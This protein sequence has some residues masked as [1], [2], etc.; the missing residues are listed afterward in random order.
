MKKTV[1]ILS[2]T[3]ILLSALFYSCK[4][5]DSTGSGVNS[6]HHVSVFLT[7]HATPI[8]DSVFI[9]ILA[10]DVKTENSVTGEEAWVSVHITPGIYNILRLRNGLD[11]LF[12]TGSLP[13][14]GIRKLRL[15]LGTQNSVMKNNQSFPLQ[16]HDEDR[17]V[18]VDIDESEFEINNDQIL[19]WI[20]FDAARSIQ[21]DNSGQGNN[22]G[23]RLKAHLN[24]FTKHKSGSLEGRV[25]PQSAD[26]LVMAINGTDTTMAVP[27]DDDGEFKI[28]GLHAGTYRVFYDGQNGYTDTTLNNIQVGNNEDFHLPP[29]V[30]HQ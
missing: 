26:A 30:L 15:T 14:A 4:K 24:I 16:L 2:V 1:K 25:L 23:F 6:P 20:D 10:I 17:Q 5:E 7:D 9:Q 22:N 12:A 21:V 27:D 3:L 13:N 19:F 29:I 28:M 11:T 18:T 8:F